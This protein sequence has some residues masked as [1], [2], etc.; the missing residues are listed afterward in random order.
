MEGLMK[1]SREP[2]HYDTLRVPA[3]AS[4][5]D[6]RL[7]YRRLAQKYHPDRH[8]GRDKAAGL[9]AKINGAYDVL[10][11]ADK[12]EQYDESLAE[13]AERR[14]QTWMRAATLVPG[15]TRSSWALVSGIAAV[16][17]VTM[18]FVTLYTA[19]PPQPV[20]APPQRVSQPAPP[21]DPIAPTPPIEP[22]KEPPPS[23]RPSFAATDPVTRLVRDGVKP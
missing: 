12:R 9:M 22:W 2:N 14:Q 11:D 20:I 23:Q 21:A 18:G 10:G 3:D 1:K 8:P 17:F 4:P 16:S 6:V 15:L 7:A 19:A 13:A 5:D